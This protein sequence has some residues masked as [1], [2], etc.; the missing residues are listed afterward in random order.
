MTEPDTAP[1]A[2]DRGVAATLHAILGQLLTTPAVP[3][4]GPQDAP[5]ATG[6]GAEPEHVANE[7]QT[8]A[9]RFDRLAL[10]Q[11][12]ARA[13]HRYD[14]DHGQA[15]G[16]LP[17]QYHHEQADAVMAVVQPEIDAE[18][19]EMQHLLRAEHT[20]ANEAIRREEASD[21]AAEEQRD[22]AEQA[23]AQV[24]AVR[25]LAYDY[26]VG[27]PTDTVPFHSVARAISRALD[28]PTA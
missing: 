17:S 18:R 16:D 13:L 7:A 9:Q 6:T 28:T 19:A 3:P 23:E 1:L 8:G 11:R 24:R 15:G 14:N 2:I 5:T 21:Q 10:R 20:R 4:R 26:A 25:Q 27:D 12:I 22:R